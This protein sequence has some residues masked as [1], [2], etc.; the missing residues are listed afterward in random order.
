MPTTGWRRSGVSHHAKDIPYR[1]IKGK[2]TGRR[3]QLQVNNLPGGG[4]VKD[5]VNGDLD[6]P[7]IW[8]SP[9]ILQ[10]TVELCAVTLEFTQLLSRWLI[11]RG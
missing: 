10:P 7:H 4:D 3:L 2:M 8:R 5:N 1:L 6:A 9:G 11:A